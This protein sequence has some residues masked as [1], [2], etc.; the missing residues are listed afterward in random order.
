MDAEHREGV[1]KITAEG[2]LGSASKINSQRGA[3]SEKEKGSVGAKSDRA[4]ITSR[5]DSRLVSLQSELSETQ[6]ELS[7][8]QIVKEG[9]SRFVDEFNKGGNIKAVLN[10]VKFNDKKVLIDY[11]GDNG[12][13][14][15]M[16]ML[17]EKNNEIDSLI[18][19]DTNKLTK[20][21]VE[22]ENI[23][24]S[25]LSKGSKHESVFDQ[26]SA[27]MDNGGNR[28]ASISNLNPDAV[29]RLIR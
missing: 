9:L 21:Q 20:L 5:I 24:A 12:D 25:N 22:S 17:S 23:F 19:R 29:L 18:V 13:A 16:N 26:I 2:L 10:D 7:K 15:T 11:L 1:M 8:N 14:L 4:D 6:T 28:S 3:S 27:M